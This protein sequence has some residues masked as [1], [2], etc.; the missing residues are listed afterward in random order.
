[1]AQRFLSRDEWPLVA[2]GIAAGLVT[3]SFIIWFFIT[4]FNRGA[5][6]AVLI[7][8]E[9]G[10]IP[11][12]VTRAPP[13][14]GP[15]PGLI[16]NRERGIW[17][18]LEPLRVVAR[19]LRGPLAITA[20]RI[21]WD[22]PG[23]DRFATA[24]LVTAQLDAGAA[25]RGDFLLDNVVLRTPVVELRQ[26]RPRGDW[27]F[28][29]VFAELLEGD[30]RPGP[31][32]TIRL[33]NVSV[34]DG[35]VRV[36]RPE[37]R[38]VLRAVDARM[39]LVVLSQPGVP[40]PY[41]R[42]TTLSMDFVQTLPE[43]GQLAIRASDGLFYFP[44]GRVRFDVA[45]LT[46]DRTQFATLR[47]VWDPADPGFGI[48][49]TGLAL[50]VRLEDVAFLTPEAF[51][52]AGTARFNFAI[53]PLPLDRTEAMLTELDARFNGSRIGGA[54]TAQFGEEFFLLRSA[55]LLL[56][57]L[58]LAVVEGFTGPLPYGGALQ[59]RVLGD[60]GDIRFDLTAALTAPQ[61]A[62]TFP[63]GITGRA[64][65]RPDEV[66]LQRVELRL[67]RTPL[68][69][70]RA[71]APALPVQGSVT[72]LVTLTGM[73]T[74]SPLTLDVRLEA[75]GGVALVEGTL[76]LTGAVPAYDLRGRLLGVQLQ[77][78]LAPDVPPA[79]LT[80]NFA[81]AGS[82][83]DPAV[84][85]S[86]IRLDGRFTGWE[87]G[88]ADT[89]HLR[90]AVRQ[91][92]LDVQSLAMRLATAEVAA[93]GSWRFLEPQAGA[94][95]YAVNVASLRPFGPYLPWV[96]DE[97]AAGSLVAAGSI[98]GT[99]ERMRLSGDLTATD[100][101]AREWQATLLT[102]EYDV[103]FGGDQLPVM[104][105][106][107]RGRGLVAPGVGALSEATLSLNLTSPTFVLALD[108]TRPG[109]GVVQVA[110]SG[111]VP[112]DGPR[113][114]TLEQ[115]VFD[116]EDGRWALAQPTVIRWLGDE[117]MVDGLVLEEARTGGR[118]ALDGRILPMVGVDMRFEV[119]AL[120]TGEI[121]ALL[122]LPPHVQGALWAE[123]TVV[124]AAESPRVE[125]A[126]RLEDGAVE[127]VPVQRLEGT[128]SHLAEVT[129]IQAQVL[130][131][132]EGYLEVDVSLPSIV[133][134]GATPIFEL[135]DGVPLDGRLTARQFAL[136]AVTA[137]FPADLR[138][139]TGVV[140]AEVLLSGT[141]DAPVVAGEARL[142]G[143]SVLIM[144][145]N[146]TWDEISG[147]VGFDGRRLLIRDLRARSDGWV[148]IG[149]Q[150]VLERLDQPVTDLT[151]TF[152]GFR[153]IGVEGQRDAALFGQLALAGPPVGLE[154]T[155]SLRVDDG[156]VAIPAMGGAGQDLVDIAG[157]AP[158]AGQQ[159]EA[160]QGA[161][162]ENLVIHNLIVTAGD[163]AWFIAEEARAQLSGQL[164]VN[165]V[166][167]A[168][169]ITGTL[170]GTRGQYILIAGPIV[171]RFDIVSA[172][173]RFLGDPQPNPVVDITARR[174][175][176]D[177]GGRQL[178]VNVRITGTLDNPRLSLAGG[179]V[180][181]VAEAELLSF[182][183][184]GQP[185]FAL[186]GEFVPGEALL[187]QAF[188]GGFAE[189]L[190]IELERGLGGF[191]LDIFQ[192]RLGRGPLGG[193]GAPTLVM[194]RQLRED[195]FVTVETGLTALF[196]GSGA[197]E[198][199]NHWAVRLD[200]TFAPQSRA[201]LAWEPVY[202]GRAFRGAVFAL[203][204]TQQRQQFLVEVRRR[205]TY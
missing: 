132:D 25:A 104:V 100:V 39:P 48:T 196:G 93:S 153:P 146:Q 31:V 186:G 10:A 181:G 133:R 96:G 121:L 155:G 137:L 161:V 58:Q 35:T 32:R 150:V 124:G 57:P 195:V 105:V 188:V 74:R 178:D 84:M 86:T 52:A 14:D 6:D 71:V 44:D 63:V 72:G 1:M 198:L 163:G 126:F 117:W 175:V 177:P 197:G 56:D 192:I 111:S 46:L 28:Q 185:T 149:G 160:A 184:F 60:D 45:S 88:P 47:G 200:W 95:T 70:L 75:G 172:Q 65:L 73:P 166:G 169:P 202:A 87:A 108:G 204:L 26:P 16:G 51:P 170:S 30:G 141:A 109:G 107:A 101:R 38:F 66:L 85:M 113:L 164:V 91:G 11:R 119:A 159:L 21:V 176:F 148:V 53:R 41:L 125:V 128:I 77:Q 12:A 23:G 2:A 127:D 8:D 42:V 201:T 156:F 22:D 158:V 78:V 7:N 29:A 140:N 89:V 37:Q 190:A 138:D 82:G 151:A 130:V 171:R 110:A 15:G 40:D 180:A 27:N 64:L 135:V 90:A 80:A 167:D 165:K 122:G 112:E 162:F 106:D 68:A 54:L 5:G 94:I 179:D 168:I 129:R 120:P 99:L 19:P 59:G 143:G 193:L 3:A 116:L 17:G 83:F 18:R 144:D 123:G 61:V 20:R 9:P 174:I 203:P 49:A 152:D 103:A 199:P 147:D 97:V 189:L 55:D 81:F 69:A 43:T 139:V 142:A 134:I 98:S 154:L 182:L 205:W 24:D 102:A 194:G 157:P 118:V 173:M 191:G 92:V 183:I 50:D 62:G 115:V 187:E 131:D 76:D 145:L 34:A 36:T 13:P 33:R 67:D 136:S 114:I 79:A 4:G